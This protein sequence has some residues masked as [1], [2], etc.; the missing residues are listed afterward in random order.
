MAD[1]TLGEQ[2]KDEAAAYNAEN[3]GERWRIVVVIGGE[4]YVCEKAHGRITPALERV[5]EIER[6]TSVN[7]FVIRE[8]SEAM[9]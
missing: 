4:R 3:D 5:V 9:R 2:S 6:T 1:K 7:A 8:T